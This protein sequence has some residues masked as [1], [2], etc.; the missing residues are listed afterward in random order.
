MANSGSLTLKRVR[1]RQKRYRKLLAD[2]RMSEREKEPARR[3]MLIE[4]RLLDA[5]QKKMGA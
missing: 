4:N 2:R 3:A 1:E 5:L